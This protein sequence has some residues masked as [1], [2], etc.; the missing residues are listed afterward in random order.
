[1]TSDRGQ[2]FTDRSI[3][4]KNTNTKVIGFSVYINKTTNLI[5]GVQSIY[6]VGEFKKPGG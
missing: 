6:K 3:L 2:R 1:M 4:G 5:C